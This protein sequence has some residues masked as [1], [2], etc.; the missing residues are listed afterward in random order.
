MLPKI[1]KIEIPFSR[2]SIILLGTLFASIFVATSLISSSRFSEQENA[3][4]QNLI[5][6]LVNQKFC[7]NSTTCADNIHLYRKGGNRFYLKLY[8]QN[9]RIL[10]AAIGKYLVQNANKY[11]QNK[12]IT[13]KAFSTPKAS[14]F[15]L[16]D[17]FS[18]EE[19]LL[20]L[21]IEKK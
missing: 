7:E 13:F 6:E 9:D 21:D 19:P 11:N 12:A 15:D 4:Y 16:K 17:F 2:T 5:D 14:A 3:L 10:S 18:P 8:N 20:R 1:N